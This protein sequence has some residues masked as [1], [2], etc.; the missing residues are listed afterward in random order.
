MQDLGPALKGM[1]AVKDLFEVGLLQKAADASVAA[2]LA[3]MK[4]IKPGLYEYE[5]AALMEY[6]FRRRGC[7]RPAYAS[8]AAS[9]ANAAF[10]HY[11]ENSKRL[12]SGDLILLDV[13]GEYSMYAADVT[14][15]LPVNGKYTGRQRELYRLVRGAEFAVIQAFESGQSTL[16][17]GPH[18]LQGAYSAYLE[19][20]LIA[21][22]AMG[23]IGH[24]VGLN[25]HDGGETAA[26]FT[27]P[28][29]P[30]NVF[31]IEPRIYLPD[32]NIGIAIEDTFWIDPD[33]RLVNL[34]SDLPV[35]PEDIE[36]A[37][38]SASQSPINLA[39]PLAATKPQQNL[40]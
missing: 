28:L 31:N 16:Y 18:S 24:L 40:N 7:A 12:A 29:V 30:G 23:G 15:T 9:G 38:G 8:I 37:M 27:A 11:T 26:E 2:H 33:G 32:E 6:E 13:A 17:G 14:R 3:A 5:V 22:F 36:R 1:R 21:K 25:V 10:D 35:E 34:T 4:A 39:R 19:S 20:H